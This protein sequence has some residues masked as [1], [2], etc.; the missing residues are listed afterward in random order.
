MRFRIRTLLPLAL[1]LTFAGA[2][3]LAGQGTAGDSVHWRAT[4]AD[5]DSIARD[6]SAPQYSRRAQARIRARDSL[7]TVAPVVQPP[8]PPPPP[9]A[10]YVSTVQIHGTGATLAVGQTMQLVTEQQAADGSPLSKP[11]TWSAEPSAIA[12]VSSSGLLSGKSAGS[13]TV[14]A[15]ADTAKATRVFTVLASSSS[16]APPVDS[17]PAPAPVPVPTP[18]PAPVPAPVVA[19][20]HPFA[21]PANGAA[22]AEFPRVQVDTSYPAIA[23]RYRCT[24]AQAC[25]DTAQSGDEILLA[26]GSVFSYVEGR[27]T[28]RAGWVVIKTDLPDSV[29]GR[30]TMTRDRAKTLNLATFTTN[31]NQHAFLA[32]SRAHHIRLVGVRLTTTFSGVNT[33]AKA[34]EGS[35]NAADIPHHIIFDRTV[36]DPPDGYDIRRGYWLDADTS[37]VIKSGCYGIHSNI[38]DSQCGLVINARGPQL[39]ALNVLQ[40]GHMGVMI[41]GGSPA[42]ANAIP[43]DIVFEGNYFCRPASWQNIWIIKVIFELKIGKR[44]LVQGN[45]MCNSYPPGQAGFAYN[46]K[47]VDQDWLAPWSQTADVTVRWNSHSCIA[48]FMQLAGK[49]ED[50][51]AIPMA[52]IAVYGNVA[53]SVNVAPCTSGAGNGD[54]LLLL[55]VADVVFVD[56]WIRNPTNRSAMYVMGVSP[57]L[58]LE[59]NTFGGEYGIKYDNG[60]TA[61]TMTPGGSYAG[62][63]LLPWG[64]LGSAWPPAPSDSTRAALLSRV[65]TP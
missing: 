31:Q 48:G 58:V 57:R 42:V 52:R 11:V 36:A 20:S 40:T 5:L 61:A 43:S 46:L 13:V 59:R 2:A 22:L 24:N 7:R 53:D 15:R 39:W 62:N 64:A 33:L 14:I 47:T 45:R 55:G 29:I 35:S 28:A 65:P 19:F 4:K 30:G 51:P 38:S 3:P 37:A 23:R 44:V 27:P 34:G 18:V 12:T 1:L 49:P 8:A 16:P 41:G 26:P 56:N 50:A 21:P 6:K 63:V 32:K 54:A 25:L 9:P 60:G 17:Q 10:P